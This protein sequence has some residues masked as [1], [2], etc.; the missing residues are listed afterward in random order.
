MTDNRPIILTPEQRVM[1]VCILMISE[2][3]SWRRGPD[4]IASVVDSVRLIE[5]AVHYDLTHP[6]EPY[7]E[8]VD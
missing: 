3:E 6:P 4:I 2:A 1:A 7:A 5:G 8:E